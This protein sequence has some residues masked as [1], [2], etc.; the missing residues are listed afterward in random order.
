[1]LGV[2]VLSGP[3]TSEALAACTQPQAAENEDM[4]PP[5]I[6][7]G[8]DFSEVD[9]ASAAGALS[10]MAS[11]PKGK[12]KPL[13]LVDM[14]AS[15]VLAAPA[16]SKDDVVAFD[17]LFEK[18]CG[19]GGSNQFAYFDECWSKLARDKGKTSGALADADGALAEVKEPKDRLT[20]VLIIS[21]E[22]Q[23]TAQRKVGDSHGKKKAFG[24]YSLIMNYS[25]L[26][27]YVTYKHNIFFF[28]F[29]TL[30]YIILY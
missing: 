8:A 4:G 3:G 1:M 17:E 11:P 25:Y 15:Q 5:E 10:A 29:Y 20:T 22:R 26:Y 13:P 28:N 9:A 24:L 19:A 12:E 23:I 2:A 14:S 16:S 6:S 7:D 30:Y 18:F 21:G 27:D